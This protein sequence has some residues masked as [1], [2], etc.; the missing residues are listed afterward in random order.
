MNYSTA[1]N[2]FKESNKFDGFELIHDHSI[3]HW[4]SR[5]S[6]ST[7]ES[8]QYDIG[9]PHL[10]VALRD[11]ID[12]NNNPEEIISIYAEPFLT[13][14]LKHA[15]DHE[16]TKV[17]LMAIKD[18]QNDGIAVNLLPKAAYY[19]TGS[20]IRLNRKYTD[21]TARRFIKSAAMAAQDGFDLESCKLPTKPVIKTNVHT[22]NRWTKD[23]WSGRW[24]G[25]NQ[26]RQT[27]LWFKGPKPGLSRQLLK[28]SRVEL[29]LFIQWFSGH[30]WLRRHLNVIDEYMDSSCRLCGQGEESPEHLWWECQQVGTTGLSIKNSKPKLRW[31]LQQIGRFLTVPSIAS[32]LDQEA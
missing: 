28:C 15:M 16:S 22:I 31:S 26:C 13:D 6:K 23:Y 8:V 30:G 19:E 5:S 18:L 4:S 7:L 29:G 21:D 32:L 14:I 27:K 20:K 17:G 1:V 25:L 24:Q 12:V 9:L 11:I 3:H 10:K 2:I